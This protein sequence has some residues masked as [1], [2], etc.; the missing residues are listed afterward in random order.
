MVAVFEDVAAGFVEDDFA[1]DEAFAAVAG[2]EPAF[3]AAFVEAAFVVPEAGALLD[4][5]FASGLPTALLYSFLKSENMV[6]ERF[7]CLPVA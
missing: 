1:G 6:V 2:A 5:G 7:S 3:E 4:C